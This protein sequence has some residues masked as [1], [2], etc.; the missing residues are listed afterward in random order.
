[1][2]SER[3][4]KCG[5]KINVPETALK[6]CHECFNEKCECG[7]KRAIHV[8][9]TGSCVHTYNLNHKTKR[10]ETC[11]C[12]KFI[13]Q[14][15][16]PLVSPKTSIL[17]EDSEETEP[18]EIKTETQ[19]VN[20]RL[21]PS[22]SDDAS[23]LSDKRELVARENDVGKTEMFLKRDVKESVDKENSLLN[24]VKEGN[25]SWSEFWEKRRK[26]FGK[27]LIQ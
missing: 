8:D 17:L 23:S 27:D 15:H 13:H 9:N 20:D 4:A 6:L 12:E 25:I 7:H 3:C 26:I 5:K 19:V 10:G 21:N 14:N 22:G 11:S 1:M 2:T 18:E 16:N 24:L